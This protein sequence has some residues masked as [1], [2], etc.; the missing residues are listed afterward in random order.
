MKE[1]LRSVNAC[2]ERLYYQTRGKYT[3]SLEELIVVQEE[4]KSMLEDVEEAKK[5]SKQLYE[6][7]EG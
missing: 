6:E 2:A 5:E 3:M 4:I 7:K 1:Y